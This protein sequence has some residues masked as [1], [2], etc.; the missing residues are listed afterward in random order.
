[1]YRGCTLKS[2]SKRFD[3]LYGCIFICN[4]HIYDYVAATI[5]FIVPG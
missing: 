2:K 5:G 1:M 3:L 4:G